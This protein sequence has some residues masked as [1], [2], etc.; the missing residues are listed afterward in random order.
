MPRGELQTKPQ[1]RKHKYQNRKMLMIRTNEPRTTTTIA[2]VA[3]A[4][5]AAVVDEDAIGTKHVRIVPMLP[6]ESPPIPTIKQR[7]P[8]KMRAP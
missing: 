4:D 2:V 8:L 3:V 1:P 5:A 7:N 6:A